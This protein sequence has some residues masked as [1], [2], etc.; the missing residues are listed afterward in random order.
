MAPWI[1]GR[2]NGLSPARALRDFWR[3]SRLVHGRRVLLIEDDI[4]LLR[5]MSAA[6]A[7]AGFQVMAAKDGAEGLALFEHAPADLVITDMMMP[8]VEG[9]ETILALRRR[10]AP[11]KIIAI[12]GGFRNSP[13]DCL[14]LARHVGA[15]QTLAKPFRS[16][17]L[18]F[19]A[20]A[21]MAVDPAKAYRGPGS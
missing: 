17:E 11:P 12:S 14:T 7:E 20:Q 2:N 13:D 5:L 18:L 9:V 15:D 21:L 10:V 19:L 3:G 6:F 16:S 4:E 1:D 8:I